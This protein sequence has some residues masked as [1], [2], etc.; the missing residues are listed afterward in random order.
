MK[1]KTT[2]QDRDFRD[3]GRRLL[4]EI[5]F[6]GPVFGEKSLLDPTS[7]PDPPDQVDFSIETDENGDPHFTN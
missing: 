5:L 6:Q 2:P 7:F 3:Q 1:S 4:S